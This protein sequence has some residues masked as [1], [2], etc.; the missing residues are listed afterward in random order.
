V[1]RSL[2]ADTG[3]LTATLT[4][5]TEFEEKITR[6]SSVYR[7][8]GQGI[9]TLQILTMPK[10]SKI[11]VYCSRCSSADDNDSILAVPGLGTNPVE[12]W[13]WKP[14]ANDTPEPDGQHG[15]PASSRATGSSKHFNWLQ[16]PDGLASLFPKARIML[17]DYA[18]AWKGKRKVRSTMQ[19]ICTWLLDDLREKRKVNWQTAHWMQGSYAYFL[20]DR[21]AMRS[22]AL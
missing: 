11:V 17:Y 2:I 18:S 20:H 12:C 6:Q 13:T 1:V 22:L 15:P 4:M 10:W 3:Q 5:S 19:S 9:K 21:A 14:G 7:A 8:L 16:D